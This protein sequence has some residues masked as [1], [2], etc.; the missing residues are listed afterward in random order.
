[1]RVLAFLTI[2]LAIDT[3]PLPN[4]GTQTSF[5]NHYPSFENLIERVFNDQVVF[6]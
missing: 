3:A 2:Q 6:L 5:S 1:M 4:A